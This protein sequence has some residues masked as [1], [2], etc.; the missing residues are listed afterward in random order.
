MNKPGLSVVF[1]GNGPV[2]AKSLELMNEWANI[3]LVITKKSHSI[4][5]TQHRLKNTASCA[6]Y[7]L[8]MQIIKMN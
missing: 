4:T 8:S 6:I 2:A 7:Q 3:E 1:M 5:K